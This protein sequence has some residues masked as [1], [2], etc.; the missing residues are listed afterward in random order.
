MPP[1]ARGD[2]PGAGIARRREE[3][4]V[5]IGAARDDQSVRQPRARRARRGSAARREKRPVGLAVVLE[6]NDCALADVAADES[7]GA[8]AAGGETL[9]IDGVGDER[10]CPPGDAAA[11]WLLARM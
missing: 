4:G 2:D 10:E 8:N 6:R 3:P 1:A 5:E 11:A 9:N 7:R